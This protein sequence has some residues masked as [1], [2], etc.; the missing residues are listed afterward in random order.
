MNIYEIAKLANVSI[1]TVSRVI[2]NRDGVSKKTKEKIEKIISENN[3]TPNHIA[4]SLTGKNTKSIGIIVPTIDSY[5]K[6]SIKIIDQIALENGFSLLL[7]TTIKNIKDKINFL[8]QKKVDAIIIFG[9]RFNSDEVKFIK[10]ISKNTPI[11]SF[12]SDLTSYNIPSI[13]HNNVEALTLAIDFLQSN[14]HNDILFFLAKPSTKNEILLKNIL[15][16]YKSINKYDIIYSDFSIENAYI[17]TE[18]YFKNLKN[19]PSAIIA[20]NDN[21]AIG[22]MK[23]LNKLNI[24]IPNDISIIGYDNIEIS[25]YLSPSLTTIDV[26]LENAGKIAITTIFKMLDKKEYTLINYLKPNL[27]IRESVKKI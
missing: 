15:S 21:M 10:Q 23:A 3:Y 20:A 11:F 26:D 22:I 9:L 27:I 8:I 16:N 18:K 13:V 12:G 7:S 24:S 14:N 25:K 17:V 4:Q 19:L 6:K 5:F 2:N 1:T